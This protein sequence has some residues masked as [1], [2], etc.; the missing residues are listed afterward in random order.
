MSEVIGEVLRD[1]QQAVGLLRVTG[2][3]GSMPENP[4]A[5]LLLNGDDHTKSGRQ[6]RVR[7]F[8]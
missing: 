7:G 1:L 2:Q 5:K 6:L 3:I 8:I 4:S